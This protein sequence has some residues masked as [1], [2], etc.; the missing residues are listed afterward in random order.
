MTQFLFQKVVS[1]C[2]H[3]LGSGPKAGWHLSITKTVRAE[4]VEVQVACLILRQAQDERIE[5]FVSF[6]YHPALSIPAI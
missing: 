3:D 6:K 5:S 4:L 1:E 2:Q